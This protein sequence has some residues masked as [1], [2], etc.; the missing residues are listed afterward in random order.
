MKSE[1]FIFA[2]NKRDKNEVE[3]YIRFMLTHVDTCPGMGV[4]RKD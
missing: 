2:A 4:K 3:I 1:D